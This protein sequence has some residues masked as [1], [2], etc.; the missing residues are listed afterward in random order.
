LSY[1][2]SL[3]KNASLFG[4]YGRFGNG[5]I[6]LLSMV[7]F[8]FLLTNTISTTVK[9]GKK[10]DGLVKSN[11]L[12]RLLITSCLVAVLISYIPILSVFLSNNGV[13]LPQALQRALQFLLSPT[14]G[15]LEGL[16]V[17]VSIAM[18][19]AGVL[20][21][22]E[23][24][25]DRKIIS[26]LLYSLLLI[27]GLALLIIVDFNPAWFVLLI[28]FGLFLIFSIWS[29]SFKDRVN[30]LLIPI[31]IV[32]LAFIFLFVNNFRLLGVSLP[33]EQIL[34]QVT[35]WKI[36]LSSL[37]DSFKNVFLGSGPGT[38]I[39]DFSKNKPIEF[40][41][42]DLWAIR[43][44]R[45]G[46]YISEWLTTLGLL[47]FV[48]YIFL[49]GL[50]IS[51]LKLLGKNSQTMPYALAFLALL[52]SGLVYYQ[53]MILAFC[54]WL[55][56]AIYITSLRGQVSEI[57]LRFDKIPELSLVFYVLLGLLFIA[58]LTT[59]Y[60]G[61]RL[62]LAEVNHAR[63]QKAQSA[64]AAIQ[65]LDKAIKLNP[66]VYGY[67]IS[68][69]RTL[70]SYSN[71]ELQK[72]VNEAE[73]SRVQN[74][75]SASI[76]HAQKATE[77][78]PHS[79]AAWENLAFLYKGIQPLATDA[80]EWSLK[81]MQKAIEL[82]EYNPILHTEIGKLY[83]AMQD[84][85]NARKS[86]L[87]AKEVKP[88][89]TEALIQEALIYEKEDDIDTAILKLE[90]LVG[91]Y[92]LDVELRF[93]LGRLYFNKDLLEQAAI[94]FESALFIN[95][96]HQNSLYSLAVIYAEQGK[97]EAAISIFEELLK[98]NLGNQDIIDRL[99]DL[100]GETGE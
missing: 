10:Q 79:I 60:F 1:A 72:V 76:N 61:A 41:G 54:F 35:S 55:I 75:V 31:C 86:F 11:S 13:I 5:L 53:N 63:A 21:I 2:F 27:C 77:M 71:I 67:Y 62:Y 66:N 90:Q 51:K 26:K 16:A 85:E 80:N 65:L 29:R 34:D 4:S 7:M 96:N 9:G 95:P 92:S 91:N 42:T 17:F 3:D 28:S 74:L 8:Y 46:S 87:K 38:W 89:Y 56:L 40:N 52:A 97:K 37:T 45:S 93:H 15:S 36:T 48:S 100:R 88:D 81:S 6:G 49:I 22:Q 98:L 64:E 32:V 83:L 24:K 84:L 19:I 14:T 20:L 73:L 43:F 18:V 82:E 44:D 33:K 58:T 47:G 68:L 94:Q 50:S 70:F 25:E 39:Y 12:V 30:L 59:Y 69:S 57:I 99:K 78:A 23:D